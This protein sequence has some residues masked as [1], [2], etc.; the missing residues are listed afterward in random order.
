MSGCGDDAG[1]AVCCSGA[2]TKVVGAFSREVELTICPMCEGFR[3]EW[4]LAPG[5]VLGNVGEGGRQ[6]LLLGRH[7]DSACGLV[8]VLRV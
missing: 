1:T 4:K 8:F 3:R 5:A 6:S 2:V 7:V